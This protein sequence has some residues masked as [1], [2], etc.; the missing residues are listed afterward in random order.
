MYFLS[1]GKQDGR[2]MLSGL[3]SLPLSCGR[4]VKIYIFGR[5][6]STE[7][8]RSAHSSSTVLNPGVF[9]GTFLLRGE[10]ILTVCRKLNFRGLSFINDQRFIP[11]H[12]VLRIDTLMRFFEIPGINS[13]ETIAGSGLPHGRDVRMAPQE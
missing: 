10:M 3:K 5:D 7:A 8:I 2:L 6:W 12:G 13:F 4:P 1:P 11:H 9:H